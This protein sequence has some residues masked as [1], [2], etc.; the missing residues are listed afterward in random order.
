VRMPLVGERAFRPGSILGPTATPDRIE[1]NK[2]LH[3]LL[4]EGWRVTPEKAQEL[5]AELAGNPENL[6]VRLRLISYYGQNLINDARVRHVLWMIEHHPDAEA[7]QYS[8]GI[9]SISPP[10][11]GVNESAE[12]A[13]A[14]ALWSQ[15]ASRFPN[16]TKVVANAAM[17]V[18]PETGFQ[19]I[20]A[21]RIA[22]P[23]NMEWIQWLAK[24][25]ADAIRWTFWDGKSSLTF[26][27]DAED[28]RYP[29]FQL[30][31]PVC[32]TLKRNA[33]SSMDGPLL[34]AIGESLL[35]EVRLL[36]EKS[37]LG[38]EWSSVITPEVQQLSV[39]GEQLLSRGR[40]LVKQPKPA[41]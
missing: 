7:F 20:E 2:R 15:Q 13:R 26:T 36:R 8:G 9:L 18:D 10:G 33:E 40:M 37:G 1:E 21:A 38:A 6:P 34:E 31:L 4:E 19:L 24:T 16:D 29:P 25:Y 11:S 12:Y 41:K 39:Y 32:S 30:P 17:N 28:Y 22:Q 23:R 35:R 3:S 14:Q 5:E 27:G